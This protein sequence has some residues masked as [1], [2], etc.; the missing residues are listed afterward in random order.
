MGENILVWN[1]ISTD[2]VGD[3]WGMVVFIQ[4]SATIISSG[5][6]LVS[7][8]HDIVKVKEAVRKHNKNLLFKTSWNIMPKYFAKSH[9]G[10]LEMQI[11]F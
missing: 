7:C 4:L 2:D 3:F 11:R 1:Y 5:V 9:A 10:G 8:I 6:V